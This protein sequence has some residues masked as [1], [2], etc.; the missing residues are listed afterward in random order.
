MDIS[1]GSGVIIVTTAIVR[2][3]MVREVI[4]PWCPNPELT[5][6]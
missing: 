3:A 4:V 5:G 1:S 6:Q 2:R